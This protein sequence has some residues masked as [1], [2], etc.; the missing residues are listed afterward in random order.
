MAA[1]FTDHTVDLG[2]IGND[3]S[4][5]LDL[6]WEMDASSSTSNSIA[7]QFLIANATPGAGVPEPAGLAF[8]YLVSV[9]LTRRIT[10]SRG[11]P[12]SP[13]SSLSVTS[14]P[15]APSATSPIAILDS[16]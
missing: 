7:P 8:I 11:R 15:S 12:L 4:G 10:R 2:P 13:P 14:K 16:R 6:S 3:V 9:G 1:Y 5:T